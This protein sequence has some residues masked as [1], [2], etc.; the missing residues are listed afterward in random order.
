MSN[1]RTSSNT[2]EAPCK[3]IPEVVSPH[4]DTVHEVPSLKLAEDEASGI[5]ATFE[6]SVKG[7]A[8][9]IIA[10]SLYSVVDENCGWVQ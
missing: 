10:R 3:G 7:E 9:V 4:P 5:V 1:T 8:S 6:L 2:F